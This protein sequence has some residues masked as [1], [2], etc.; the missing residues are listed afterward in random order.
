MDTSYVAPSGLKVIQELYQ[1]TVYDA[2]LGLVESQMTVVSGIALIVNGN[3]QV[4]V[5]QHVYN[6]FVGDDV[7]PAAFPGTVSMAD[8]LGGSGRKVT[9]L[10]FEDRIQIDFRHM[11]LLK[12]NPTFID[13]LKAIHDQPGMSLGYMR[14]KF[15]YNE[16]TFH[17][18]RRKFNSWFT[19]VTGIPRNALHADEGYRL[20]SIIRFG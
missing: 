4:E 17:K 16:S 13:L 7:V 18:H 11:P 19:Q 6:Y 3:P 10:L 5:H 20:L 1:R 15:G 8:L 12:I 2:T 14:K 9:L